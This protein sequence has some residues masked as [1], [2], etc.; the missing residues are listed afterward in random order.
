MSRVRVLVVDDSPIAARYLARALRR[1]G[2]IDVVGIAADGLEAV[3]QTVRLQPDVVTMDIFMPVLGGLEAIE[4]IMAER[5]TPILVVT[6]AGSRQTEELTFQALRRGALDLVAKPEG[7][8]GGPERE[9]QLRK[10]VRFLSTVKVVR[11]MRWRGEDRGSVPAPPTPARPS[12]ARRAVPT[13]TSAIIGIAASTGGPAALSRI[14]RT[15]PADLPATLLVAL[16]IAP[17]F[18]DGLAAWLDRASAARVRLARHGETLPPGEVLL[19]PRDRH[20]TVTSDR[21]VCL[22]RGMSGDSF[23]PS[24][25]RLFTSLA[26]GLGPAAVG[27]ILT[28]MGRDGV[29]GLHLIRTA[30]GRT[31][32][33]DEGSC[34]VFGMPH[35]AIDAGAI[36]EVIGLDEVPSVILSAA[37]LDPH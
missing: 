37:N 13:R 5:P 27:I 19:A 7:G 33:Q 10:M 30:G 28:G 35:A 1:D 25:D 20:L 15:L 24:A 3:E 17:G 2:D 11:H 4:R 16:H 9:E 22:V 6:A 12:T 23:V 36:E 29:A 8:A 26:D 14:V 18:V 31:F 21:T 34:A 32:A